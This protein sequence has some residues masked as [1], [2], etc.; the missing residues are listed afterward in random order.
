MD[1]L[2]FVI[3]ASALMGCILGALGTA[4]AFLVWGWHLWGDE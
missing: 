3:L 1:G 4:Y 2:D